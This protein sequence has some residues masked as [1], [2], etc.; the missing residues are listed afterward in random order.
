M[1]KGR[2]SIHSDFKQQTDPSALGS[3]KLCQTPLQTQDELWKI[4]Q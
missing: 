1:S 3:I 4:E 2:W